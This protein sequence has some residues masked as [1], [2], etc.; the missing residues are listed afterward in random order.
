MNVKLLSFPQISYFLFY[1][2]TIANWTKI[3][4][5]LGSDINNTFDT[6][7]IINH[8]ARKK[9]KKKDNL[10]SYSINSNSD[11][12]I[13]RAVGGHKFPIN[14]YWTGAKFAYRGYKSIK[15][16]GYLWA[17]ARPLTY[18]RTH[19]LHNRAGA[20]GARARALKFEVWKTNRY[21]ERL[22]YRS[23]GHHLTTT[24]W[25]RARPFPPPLLPPPSVSFQS[26][27][28]HLS[29]HPFPSQ[30]LTTTAPLPSLSFSLSLPRNVFPCRSSTKPHARRSIGNC[31]AALDNVQLT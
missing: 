19:A 4:I 31:L 9:K 11:K 25:D 23:E 22:R 26:R 8:P 16:S 20:R 7:F 24:Q 12:Y 18:A 2:L 3:A 17:I 5:N 15:V 10:N 21:M 14:S 1:Y 28:L 13:R 30:H 29:L 27:D 6:H